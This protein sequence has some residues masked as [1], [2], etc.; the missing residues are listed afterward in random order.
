[1]TTIFLGFTNN[2]SIRKFEMSNFLKVVVYSQST[3]SSGGG[4]FCNKKSL[5][6]LHLKFFAKNAENLF[7]SFWSKKKK[8]TTIALLKKFLF[9]ADKTYK[10]LLNSLKTNKLCLSICTQSILLSKGSSTALSLL[11]VY[12]KLFPFTQA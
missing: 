4:Y 9:S 11:F 1:M 3:H 7:Q 8:A 10:L 6:V 5:R 2:S 12:G